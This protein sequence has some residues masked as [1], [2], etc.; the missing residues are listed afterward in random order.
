MI[1]NTHLCS[2]VG[3]MVA[4][5]SHASDEMVVRNKT[6]RGTFEGYEK[7]SFMFFDSSNDMIKAAKGAVKKL[8]LNPPCKVQLL[9]SMKKEPDG[10]VLKGYSSMKFT[11]EDSN[12]E[13]TIFANNVKSITTERPNALLVA[14]VG[15]DAAGGNKVPARIDTEPL[16]ARPDLTDGQTRALSGY[17]DAR[18][19]Y[20]AFVSESSRMVAEMDRMRGA[21]R[22]ELL[23]ELRDRKNQ[24]QPIKN[25]VVA[26]T[27][28]LKSAF[29]ELQ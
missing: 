12:G 3:V 24:E 8:T 17:M 20:D 18:E 21:R 29:P 26:A 28:D 13:T 2:I 5:A 23:A 14:A 15:A 10:Y 9:R 7:N 11:V 25:A 1:R 4:C 6:H 19:R 16:E 22:T 27:A